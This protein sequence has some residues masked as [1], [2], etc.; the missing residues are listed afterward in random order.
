MACHPERPKRSEGSRRGPAVAFN[1][2][3]KP[4]ILS[5]PK[6]LVILSDRSAAKGVEGPAVAFRRTERP[7]PDRPGFQSRQYRPIHMFLEINSCGEAAP[8]A[9]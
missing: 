5:D 7:Q 9:R 6:W 4:V 8:R 1:D 3:L 2:S